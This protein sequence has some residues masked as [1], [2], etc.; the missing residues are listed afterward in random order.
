MCHLRLILI[1]AMIAASTAHA[2]TAPMSVSPAADRSSETWVELADAHTYHHCH[3]LPRHTRCHKSE[4]LP[5]QWRSST[6]A[7]ERAAIQGRRHKL[8]MLSHKRRRSL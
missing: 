2:A 5:E 1:A 7:P 8:R 6:N 3:S 4:W